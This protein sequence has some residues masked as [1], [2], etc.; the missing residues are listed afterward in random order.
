[1]PK[2][3]RVIAGSQF[4]LWYVHDVRHDLPGSP[5]QCECLSCGTI[6][7]VVRNNL[8][9][10]RSVSCGCQKIKTT[11]PR[12]LKPGDRIGSLIIEA[13]EPDSRGR[14]AFRCRCLCGNDLIN[15]RVDVLRREQ[16]PT[17]VH[18]REFRTLFLWPGADKELMER[19]TKFHGLRYFDMTGPEPVEYT[20]PKYFE[21]MSLCKEK[22]GS[23]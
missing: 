7:L 21:I 19:Y 22:G 14:K 2:P 11:H 17:C 5:A 12:N 3:N 9:S 23:R 20:N 15:R 13:A 4:G 16:Y 10:G 1:M 18:C 6:K 8:T